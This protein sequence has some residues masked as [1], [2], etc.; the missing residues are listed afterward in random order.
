MARQVMGTTRECRTAEEMS[1][2]STDISGGRR[3]F[4][5]RDLARVSS[6]A[7][8]LSDSFPHISID[9]STSSRAY[10]SYTRPLN[11]LVGR[12]DVNFFTSSDRFRWGRVYPLRLPLRSS[13]PSTPE[14]A[15][16]RRI[17]RSSSRGAT[18]SPNPS[19]RSGGLR[20]KTKASGK[21]CRSTGLGE[22]TAWACTL[23]ILP[24]RFPPTSGYSPSSTSL[25]CMTTRSKAR[26][27]NSSGS[28]RS[29]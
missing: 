12:S 3:H 18:V 25:I 16:P 21:G 15:P 6:I 2:T 27:R 22:S 8:T 5:T 14:N 23:A 13:L 29:S 7:F 9:A 1:N 28:S 19:S 4:V 10:A 24:A 11:L 20:T 17:W 26:C